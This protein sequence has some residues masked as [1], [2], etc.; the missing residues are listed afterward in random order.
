VRDGSNLPEANVSPFVDTDESNGYVI[1]I[2]QP[3]FW[4]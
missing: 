3:I 2:K 1:D 4:E